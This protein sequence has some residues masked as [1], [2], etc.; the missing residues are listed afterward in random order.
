M[1]NY[2]SKSTPAEVKSAKVKY[3]HI[4]WEG[5]GRGW[6]GTESLTEEELE[7]EVRVN[8]KTWTVGT[9]GM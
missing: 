7:M 6:N 2:T 4:T 9:T 3:K 8:R 1:K 5:R